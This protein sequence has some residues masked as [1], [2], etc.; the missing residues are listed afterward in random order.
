MRDK[1]RIS[2]WVREKI[3]GQGKIWGGGGG[4]GEQYFEV[5]KRNVKKSENQRGIGDERQSEKA[6]DMWKEERKEE[7]VG[8]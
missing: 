7:E 8:K 3:N 1:V 5:V 6:R 2:F 4:G